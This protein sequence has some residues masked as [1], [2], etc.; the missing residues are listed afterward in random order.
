MKN[1]PVF[2][3]ESGTA[4]LILRE[5]PY[6]AIAY[7]LARSVLPGKLETFVL[8]C[9]DFCRAAGAKEVFFAPADPEEACPWEKSTEIFSMSCPRK[10][11][12]GGDACLIPVLPETVGT[13]REHYNRAMFPV[14]NA[15]T[16]EKAD[17]DRLLTEGGG[18]FVHRDG[19]LLGLGQIQDGSLEAVIS[20]EPRQGETVV[21][22]L[23]S[24]P[25]GKDDITLQVASANLRALRLYERLG[26]MKTRVLSRW[27]RLPQR[28]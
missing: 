21:R 2:T 17:E 24:V 23:A 3:L 20:L 16:M 11:L 27:Y 28:A 14:P 4:T 7:V 18:Y 6:K 10:R 5:I 1:I 13:Y 15:A 22:A 25:T 9:R 19:K 12:L 26:F 8:E